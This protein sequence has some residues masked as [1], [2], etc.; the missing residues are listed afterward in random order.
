MFQWQMPGWGFVNVQDNMNPHILRILEG[1]F[2]DEAAMLAL[3]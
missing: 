3:P 2:S 1:T